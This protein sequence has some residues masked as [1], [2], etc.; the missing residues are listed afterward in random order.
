MLKDLKDDD[1]DE[2]KPTNFEIFFLKKIGELKIE[3]QFCFDLNF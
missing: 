2:K 3:K 1:S